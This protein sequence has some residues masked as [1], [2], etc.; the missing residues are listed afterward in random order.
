MQRVPGTPASAMG[1]TAVDTPSAMAETRL[2]ARQ[3]DQPLVSGTAVRAL[4][5]DGGAVLVSRHTD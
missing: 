2:R 1:A 4:N 5:K 3:A